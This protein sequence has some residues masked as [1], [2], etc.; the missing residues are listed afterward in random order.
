M[1]LPLDYFIPVNKW[2]IVVYKCV[3]SALEGMIHIKASH[4]VE[5]EDED[6][7]RHLNEINTFTS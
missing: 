6:D 2:L 1:W 5:S 3:V 4:T 7:E